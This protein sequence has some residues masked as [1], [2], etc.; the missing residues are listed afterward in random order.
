MSEK[1]RF[2]LNLENFR[3][4]SNFWTISILVK[5]S[6]NYVFVQISENISIFVKIVENFDFG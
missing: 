4:W 5:I 1:F 2:F 6:E 3:F